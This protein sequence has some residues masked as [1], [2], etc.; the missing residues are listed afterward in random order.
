VYPRRQGD[1]AAPPG[2]DRRLT[3]TDDHRGDDPD[4]GG[5]VAGLAGRR[6]LVVGASSGI[7]RA[8]ALGA[9]G[10]G[11]R[12]AVVA[13]RL[14]L[15]E[16]VVA[17]AGATARAFAGDVTDPSALTRAVTDATAWL[18]GLDAVVYATGMAPLAGLAATTAAQW[19][20]VL[21]TNVVGAALV[22]SATLPHLRRPSAAGR[23]C[24]AVLSSHSVGDPWPGLGAYAT[25]KAALV[26]LA[27]ALRAE[28]PEVRVLVVTVG[29]TATSFADQWDPRAAN[30]ALERWLADGHLRHEVLQPAEVATAILDALAGGGP[31]ELEVIGARVDGGPT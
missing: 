9:A 25:S 8:V 18:G 1:Q 26:E 19:Q 20:R 21:A 16:E 2:A 29:D 3:R 4:D 23:G 27:R 5:A 24:V 11:A 7:G 10:S 13:R 22:A 28:E 31:D 15:L 30:V 14:P 17:E 6:M 12:V